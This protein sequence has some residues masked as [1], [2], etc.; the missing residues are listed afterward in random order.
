MADPNTF[1]TPESKQSGAHP[2]K[3]PPPDARAVRDGADAFRAL[4]DRVRQISDTTCE[5]FGSGQD[6]RDYVA[7][8]RAIAESFKTNLAG[9][10]AKHREGYLRAMAYLLSID[11]DNYIAADDDWDPIRITERAFRPRSSQ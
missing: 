7:M 8:V 4:L 2:R 1:A 6:D 5:R 3:S 11:A 10:S 9:T